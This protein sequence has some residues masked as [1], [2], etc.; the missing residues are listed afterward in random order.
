MPTSLKLRQFVQL[1]KTDSC[2]NISH[3]VFKARQHDL[4]VPRTMG[5]VAFV[6]IP[7][8]PMQTPDTGLLKQFWGT[9]E[10]AAFGGSKIFCSVKAKGCKRADGTD[11][12]S[13]VSSWKG[14]G[15]I[16]DYGQFIFTGKLQDWVH[17]TVETVEV[18]KND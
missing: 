14:M 16:L 12:S 6:G 15:S 1:V 18:N 17:I 4:V 9:G 10:H 8:H 5:A 11:H 7:A 3:V 2:L 13:F